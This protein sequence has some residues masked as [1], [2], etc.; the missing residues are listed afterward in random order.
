MILAGLDVE[1]EDEES[2]LSSDLTSADE[3]GEDAEIL[4][5]QCWARGKRSFGVG[6]MP[7]KLGMTTFI[8]SLRLDCAPLTGRVEHSLG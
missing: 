5:S 1:S 7:T 6:S 2:G 8:C 4:V 3:G